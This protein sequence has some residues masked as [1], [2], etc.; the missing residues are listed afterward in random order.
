MRLR[1]TNW[2]AVTRHRFSPS[3]IAAAHLATSRQA[4]KAVTSHRTPNARSGITL[5][6]LLVVL[7]IIGLLAALSLPAM[8]GMTQANILS[9]ATRQ[10]LDDFSLAR[11]LAIKDRT[12]VFV[13]FVPTNIFALPMPTDARQYAVASNLTD[14]A[15][16]T[17]AIFTDRSPGD[18]P[19]R[20]NF[21]YMR[22]W[23]SLP[24]GTMI[25]PGSFS[26]D[27]TVLPGLPSAPFPYPTSGV[28]S[29]ALPYIGFDQNG[30]LIG[31]DNLGNLQRPW[32]EQVLAVARGSIFAVRDNGGNVIDLDLQERPP[33]S[34]LLNL[35]RINGLTGRGRLEQPQIQ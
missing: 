17:Y 33:G 13:V 23:R 32:P 30:S 27:G 19:G 28:N 8:K 29:N 21:R 1:P 26:G 35:I 34:G 25:T 20:P 16:T 11:Q 7:A 18:Q 4:E 24:D 31:L 15:F 22:L 6:E 10:L 12:S 2:R 14:A 5:T 3:R 9:S